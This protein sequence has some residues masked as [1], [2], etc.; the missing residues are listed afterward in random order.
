[1]VAAVVYETASRIYVVRQMGHL[2]EESLREL[3][4][5]MED[6]WERQGVAGGWH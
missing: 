6:H 3:M 4:E 5:T 1:M 2:K